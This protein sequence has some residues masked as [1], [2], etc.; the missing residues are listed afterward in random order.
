MVPLSSFWSYVC[1]L[2]IGTFTH[3]GE[4]IEKRKTSGQPLHSDSSR[5]S[6]RSCQLPYR[7]LP[8]TERGETKAEI[9]DQKF[10]NVS[11]HF[12]EVWA[13]G[14]LQDRSDSLMLWPCHISLGS[15]VMRLLLILDGYYS[16][17]HLKRCA[18]ALTCKTQFCYDNTRLGLTFY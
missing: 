5:I 14:E 13:K 15:Y 4:I 18:Q 17:N 3:L 10:S 2:S 11:D 8:V 7:N 6:E 16:S 12:Y 1:L 9:K